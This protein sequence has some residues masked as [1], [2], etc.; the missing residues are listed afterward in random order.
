MDT[1]P[2]LDLRIPLQK[3]H[4][5]D[6]VVQ[7]G[8][9]TRAAEA[10]YVSQ[11]VVSAHIR[12]LEERL[13]VKLFYRD[14]RD[15]RLTEAGE[16][17]HQWAQDLLTRTRE[18]SR[19]L[20][21]M[22][23]GARGAVDLG[24]SKTIGSYMLPSVL[25]EFRKSHPN[26]EITL[27]I[28]DTDRAL[29]LTRTGVLDFVVLA[30][31][32]GEDYQGLELEVIGNDELVL[33]AA[34]GFLA[35]TKVTLA[36]IAEL[37]FIEAHALRRS[38]IDRQLRELGIRERKSVVK[39]GHPEAMKRAAVRG[40]GVTMLFRSALSTLEFESG[41]LVEIPVEGLELNFPVAIV[42]RQNKTF[43]AVHLGLIDQIRKLF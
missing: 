26:V 36:D 18:L 14:G 10:L 38:Y 24:S 29:E 3:L 31:V 17:V 43:S 30:T 27:A 32:P 12:S 25:A 11:P 22:S 28:E 1:N 37:P 6:T 21:G 39:L 41:M 9:I 35:E 23:G 20:A 5:L 40:L 42:S 15:V 13:G 34:P 16:V 7:L 19:H 4:I 8:G 33:V 2:D